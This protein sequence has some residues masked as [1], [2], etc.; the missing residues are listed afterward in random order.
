MA[1]TSPLW[2]LFER[3]SDGSGKPVKYLTD[4]SHLSAWCTGC[5]TECVRVLRGQELLQHSQGQITRLRSAEDIRAAGKGIQLHLPYP[6]DL[7][8]LCASLVKQ[9]G[10]ASLASTWKGPS[11]IMHDFSGVIPVCGKKDTM[12]AHAQR[13][14]FADPT[15]L[16]SILSSLTGDFL[17]ANENH[18]ASGLTLQQP[19]TPGRAPL[20][21]AATMTPN[22][23]TS[24]HS[25]GS[26]PS[27]LSTSSHSPSAAMYGTPPKRL[28]TSPSL[29][30]I[31]PVG[32]EHSTDRVQAGS[33]ASERWTAT[34]NQELAE[35]LC[36]LFVMCNIPWNAIDNPQMEVWMAKWLPGAAVPDRRKLAGIYLDAAVQRAR[37]RT[38]NQVYGKLGT[39]QSDG[40]KDI[41]KT[42]VVASLMAVENQV[43]PISTHNMTGRP[44]TG[45]EHASLIKSD[46]KIMQDLYGVQPIAWVTDDGPDGKCARRLLRLEFPWLMMFA[47]WAHQSSL[48]AGDYLVMPGCSETIT[49][50]LDIVRWFNNHSAA[51]D[52]FNQEQLFSR[53]DRSRPLALILP[54]VTRWTTH[55]Q[56]ITRLLSLSREM[57]AC[58]LR[59]KERLLE[60]ASKSQTANA[61]ATAQKVIVSIEDHTFWTRLDRVEAHLRPLAIATNILQASSTRLDHALLVF[62]NLYRMYN[63]D[64]VE[65]EVREKL[66][67][68][69]EFRWKKAAGD[70]QDLFILAVF[71]NPYVRGHCFNR[72]VLTTADIVAL[73]RSVFQQFYGRLPDPEFTSA[74]IDYSQAVGE[75]SAERMN[76]QYHSHMAEKQETE[77]DVAQ[78]W[79]LSDRSNEALAI[80]PGRN[81][82]AKL[83][84]RIL[85]AIA[86]SGGP[87]RAFSDYGIVHT[88]LR[89]RMSTESVSKIS[90]VRMSIRREHAENG[91]HRRRLKRKL[92]LDYE[93]RVQDSSPA[94]ADLQQDHGAVSESSEDVDF[95]SIHEQLV[96]DAIAS[97]APEDDD[98]FCPE[99]RAHV[100]AHT[101]PSHP[102]GSS[103]PQESRAAVPIAGQP[104]PLVLSLDDLQEE[105]A[106]G[107]VPNRSRTAARS[108]RRVQLSLRELFVYP[109]ASGPATSRSVSPTNTATVRDALAP[110]GPHARAPTPVVS[111]AVLDSMTREERDLERQRHF[112]F[113]WRGGVRNH[114]HETLV[115]ELIQES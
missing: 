4:R 63:C 30:G 112:D 114:T 20:S 76:L 28:K 27:D 67:T 77:P 7:C 38:R 73:A 99:P 91:V 48:L 17:G 9:P 93:P 78:V 87:E 22:V 31:I 71:F 24:N 105:P 32:S 11:N 83:A 26:L 1:P 90:T 80:C 62:A 41:D 82:V 113:I 34:R 111:T 108:R 5:V 100:E 46:M 115:C 19:H 88:K 86:N 25:G 16:Q 60:I 35:D 95:S 69:L 13:C 55:E 57:K 96:V 39:G 18:P 66:L 101:A 59:H 64:D 6:T 52:L 79:R 56:S 110:S 14:P 37:A 42:N 103:V 47:C 8:V 23:R 53:P 94:T 104:R 40:W 44:K 92:G 49:S 51:L 61:A 58:V 33:A 68:R 50:A 45:K 72:E 70:D 29:P 107:T 109:I 75:F 106:T 98:E 3:V 85:S 21:P 54:A 36:E 74:L 2:Q 81:G 102:S 89:N 84:I 65:P 10:L 43:H 15:L 12:R 97:S